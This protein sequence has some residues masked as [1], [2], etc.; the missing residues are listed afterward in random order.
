M[1]TTPMVSGREL[2]NPPSD[3][4]SNIR[5]SNHSDNLLVSSWDKV[6]TTL[7][8]HFSSFYIFI[9]NFN[10]NFNSR[11][12]VSTMQPQM[13]LKENSFTADPF[14]TVASTTTLLD[15]V[16]P[17]ITLSGGQFTNPFSL[18]IHFLFL[19]FPLISSLY[20]TASF[21]PLARRIFWESMMLPFVVL[22]TLM[23]QVGFLLLSFCYTNFIY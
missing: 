20:F 2:S 21:S 18:Q 16:P 17:P 14:L 7:H 11:Q 12:C 4:I 13:C 9:Y 23:P 19:V 5:F 22:S 1:A 6:R 15:S 3:G 10:F 8:F